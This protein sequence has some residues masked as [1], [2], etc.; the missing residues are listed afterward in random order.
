MQEFD[1]PIYRI[2]SRKRLNILRIKRK[3]NSNSNSK[4]NR[5]H[6]FNMKKFRKV[7]PYVIIIAILFIFNMIWR[8]VTPV[9]D[10]LAKDEAKI[11]A[12]KVTNEEI[13]KIMEKCNYDTFFDIEKDAN[14]KIQMISANVLKINQITSD[15]AINIQKSLRNDDDKNISIAIGSLTG[16]K[17]FAGFGPKIPIRIISIGNVETNLKSEFISQGVNQTIHRVYLEVKSTVDILTP[18]STL[19]ESINN[20]VLILENVI[21]G[22]IP[23]NYYD[24]DGINNNN[25]AL[26][27]VE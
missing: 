1:K 15:I 19:S 25:Q 18:F 10:S 4:Y 8:A 21:L 26:E 6:S 9:F 11:I 24:F 5:Y 13:S 23:S 17:M 22:E 14:G 20:Q 27:V 16:V 3:R 7:F 2:Y 12:T